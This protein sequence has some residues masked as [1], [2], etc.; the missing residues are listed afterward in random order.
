MVYLIQ[1]KSQICLNFQDFFINF[2][3][4]RILWK[5]DSLCFAKTPTKRSV[6]LSKVQ[7]T[8][9]VQFPVFISFVV[10]QQIPPT[11][12][13]LIQWDKCHCNHHLG[14]ESLARC[15]SGE[16]DP[17]TDCSATPIILNSYMLCWQHATV[18][19]NTSSWNWS[20][21]P[22]ELM[23]TLSIH[24]IF[25]V[26]FSQ[27]N[28]NTNKSVSLSLPSFCSLW[29]GLK[30]REW[31]KLLTIFRNKQFS[32]SLESITKA[33]G[34]LILREKNIKEHHCSIHSSIYRADTSQVKAPIL[35]MAK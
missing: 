13:L 14:L 1:L 34:S 32:K 17:I 9:V 27:I 22:Q 28:K 10:K 3:W 7:A 6:F 35:E 21:S 2:S 12:V 18:R 8:E 5:F 20:W 24:F 31:F 23:N 25:P 29:A 30:Q 15:Q 19:N 16:S 11:H 26:Q 33:M 4:L